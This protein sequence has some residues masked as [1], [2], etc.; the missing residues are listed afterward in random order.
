MRD[1]LEMFGPT[2]LLYAPAVLDGLHLSDEQ[3]T[4]VK[5][6]QEAF[7]AKRWEAV[8]QALKRALI[9]RRREEGARIEREVTAN[10]SPMTP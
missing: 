8:Q 5:A 9:G 3:I 4:R 10:T 6:T 2:A 1:M 7:K